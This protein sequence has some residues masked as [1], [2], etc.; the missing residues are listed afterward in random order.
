MTAITT[1]I[2]FLTM[3]FSEAPP[4]RQ[5]GY[6]MA[7]GN[8]I[9]LFHAVVTL[10][11]LLVLLPSKVKNTGSSKAENFYDQIKRICYTKKKSSFNW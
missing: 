5:L 8:L 1:A 10:P 4:F 9:L 11:A 3:H 6:M 2:G 7:F